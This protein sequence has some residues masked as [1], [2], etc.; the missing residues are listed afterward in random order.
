MPLIKFSCINAFTLLFWHNDLR[1]KL[2]GLGFMY[3]IS[4]TCIVE[5]QEIM[6]AIEISHI[7]HNIKVELLL[8]LAVIVE[9]QG[10]GHC[11]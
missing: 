11:I 4:M 3:M 1:M 8:G 2:Q 6:R 10:P 7:F 9:L 5:N